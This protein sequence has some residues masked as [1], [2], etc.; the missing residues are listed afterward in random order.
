MASIKK[1]Q[2]RNQANPWRFDWPKELSGPL[3]WLNTKGNV[4]LGWD[5]HLKNKFVILD[6]WTSCCINCIHVLAELERL[7]ETFKNIPEVAF[8]GVHSAKFDREEELYMLKS[9]VRRYD[10]HHAV[11]NDCHFDVWNSLKLNNWPTLILIGPD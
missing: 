5:A 4:G 8:I 6:F 1:H 11:V 3:E 10:V 7:E 9:A 2:K